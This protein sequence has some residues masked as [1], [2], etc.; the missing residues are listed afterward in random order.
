MNKIFHERGYEDFLYWAT[1]DK[2]IFKR[3][4]DLIKDIERNGVMTGIGK[5]ERL[6]YGGGYSQ[7]IDEKNRLVYDIEENILIIKSCK[8]HYE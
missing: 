1:Q 6:K 7:R 2:K 4:A 5:P 8:G 3:I